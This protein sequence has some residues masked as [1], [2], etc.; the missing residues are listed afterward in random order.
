M[1]KSAL[2]GLLAA[3]L[4]ACFEPASVGAEGGAEGSDSE[5]VAETDA[6]EPDDDD[7]AATGADAADGEESDGAETE[8]DDADGDETEDGETEGGETEG[9][10]TTGDVCEEPLGTEE[11][12]LD[13]GDACDAGDLCTPGGCATPT[14]VGFDEPFAGTS[15]YPNRLWG[16]PVSL[17]EG[18]VS[19][20]DFHAT[21]TGGDIQLAL[22]TADGAF[23]AASDVLEDY[24]LGTHALPVE[25][26]WVDAGSY[27]LMARNTTPVHV[28]QNF[29]PTLPPS[30]TITAI[31]IDFDA[32]LPDQLENTL[33]FPSYEM[34]LWLTLLVE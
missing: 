28:G 6:V 10:D 3:L 25:P 32:E 34:N 18:W 33:T 1:K 17:D 11:N 20:L 14:T 29:D 26:T 7:G 23:V 12:C 2:L 27:L 22:Y 8:G 5:A 4:P 21:G 31:D 15:G 30:F 13:C 19:E 9:G 16:F 24:G